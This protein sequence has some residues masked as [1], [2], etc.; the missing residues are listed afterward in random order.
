MQLNTFSFLKYLEIADVRNSLNNAVNEL[1]TFAK[2]FELGRAI[3][4][5]I[6][7]R[8]C[9]NF[10]KTLKNL[11]IRKIF[12]KLLICVKIKMELYLVEL[13]NKLAEN[14]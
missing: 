8:N 3:T 2:I 11:Y 9:Q 14:V 1:I 6:Y 5:K 12:E 4:L 13:F 10:Q 7:I